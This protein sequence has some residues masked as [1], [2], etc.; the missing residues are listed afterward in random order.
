MLRRKAIL[1]MAFLAARLDHSVPQ[2]LDQ[3]DSSQGL[4]F[5]CA[6]DAICTLPY[7]ATS[8]S[9]FV[10]QFFLTRAALQ[11]SKHHQR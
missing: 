10:N 2:K 8:L 5:T 1:R 7:K 9:L 3:K 4:T 6:M 11:A